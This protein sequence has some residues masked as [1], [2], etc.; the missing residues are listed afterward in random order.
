[1]M[2]RDGSVDGVKVWDGLVGS[3]GGF[4]VARL[5]SRRWLRLFSRSALQSAGAASQSRGLRLFSRSALQSA[6]AA[7]F[8]SLGLL[9][10]G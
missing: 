6:G 2:A 9:V 1:M 8:Q 10:D 3:G 4:S 5:Y 7:A